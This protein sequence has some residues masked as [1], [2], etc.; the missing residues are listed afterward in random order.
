MLFYQTFTN[1][2]R[3]FSKF[4]EKYFLIELATELRHSPSL[5]ET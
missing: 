2:L 5:R 1:L 3:N 4:T